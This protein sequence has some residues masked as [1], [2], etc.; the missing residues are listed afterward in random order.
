MPQENV[1]LKTN[2]C[3]TR[4]HE[5]AN[6]CVGVHKHSESCLG[7]WVIT[8]P[9]P[10]PQRWTELAQDRVQWWV[11]VQAVMSL[12]FLP[13]NNYLVVQ[14]IRVLTFTQLLKYLSKFLQLA[15]FPLLF[16]CVLEYAIKIFQANQEG[17]KLKGEHQLL[18]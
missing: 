5:T 12:R 10:L 14:L 11:L 16:S 9:D 6:Y 8:L 3:T 15:S 1:K 2:S 7:V 13:P 17:L 4:R 18:V